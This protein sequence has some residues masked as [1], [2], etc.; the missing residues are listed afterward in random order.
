MIEEIKRR[1]LNFLICLD[2]LAW[3]LVTLGHS[4]PDETI[5]AGCYRMEQQGKIQGK[6]FRPVIDFVFA[7]LDKDHCLNSYMSEVKRAHS[8]YL[9]A[10]R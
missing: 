9:S 7:K 5:S 10:D 2:Q 8:K 4:A 3:N 1:L 6:I